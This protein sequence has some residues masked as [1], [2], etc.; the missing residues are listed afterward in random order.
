[1]VNVAVTSD[2]FTPV[3]TTNPLD[4]EPFTIY[5]Q[6]AASIGKV[7]N[8]LTNSDALEQRYSGVE[9]TVNHRYG[10]NLTLFGGVT[11]GWNRVA[12]SAS[13]NPNDSISVKGFDLL[14]ARVIANFSAL[15][16]LPWAVDLSSHAAF[17]TGQP[18]RRIYTVTRTVLP[19][20]RQASQD[21][22]LLP[23]GAVRK[24]AQTLVDIRLGRRFQAGYGLTVE[25][26]FEI[27]NLLNENASVQE[28]EQ[29]GA[30]LGRISRNIDGRLVRFGVKLTF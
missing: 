17:Y 20:L 4:G 21:V 26:L 8:L 22:N 30:A 18:L 19:A 6:S 25:P 5:N 7:D 27:F 29:V 15:Y 23:A 2:D 16:R 12:G 13:R 11:V 14:D 28:V 9:A 24:P 10:R 3:A 1:V